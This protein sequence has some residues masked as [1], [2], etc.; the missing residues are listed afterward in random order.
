MKRSVLNILIGLACLL[1]TVIRADE[2]RGAGPQPVF[3]K[4]W[5]QANDR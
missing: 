5:W 4:L 3:K 2:P 1:P